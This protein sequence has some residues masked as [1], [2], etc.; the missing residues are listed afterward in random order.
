[1][2]AATQDEAWEQALHAAAIFAVDPAGTGVVLHGAPGPARDHFLTFVRDLL[3]GDTPMR[4]VPAGIGDERLLG[5]LDL[6]ATLKAGRPIV[7][8]GLLAESDGGVLVL[9]MA[10][11]LAAGTAARLAAAMDDG[12]VRLERDGVGQRLAARVGVVAL[13]E[14]RDE[15][16]TPPTALADRLAMRLDLDGLRGGSGGDLG[17][18]FAA[19]AI[20]AARADLPRVTLATDTIDIL[21][22]LSL[23]LGIASLR[24]S[25]HALQVA[26]IAAALRGADLVA[27]EDIEA[28]VRYVLLPRATVLPAP[29]PDQPTDHAQEPE[30]AESSPPDPSE[31]P[32]PESQDTDGE[33]AEGQT[34]EAAAEVILAAALATLPPGLLARLQGG[35]A[36]RQRVERSGRAGPAAAIGPRGRPIGTRHGDL[37]SGRLALVDTLRTAAPRQALRRRDDASDQARRVIVT[38]DDF[39]IRRHRPRR[40]TTAIFVVDASGSAAVHRLAEVKGAI[41]LLLADCYVRRDSVALAAFRGTGAEV[42]LPPTRSLARAKKLLAG[43][44]GGGGTPVSAGLDA[45]LELADRLRRKGRSPFIVLMTD[46]RANVAR[47]GRLGR[48]LALEDALDAGRQIRAARIPALAIDTAPLIQSGP[49]SPA[50]KI[51]EA[52][53]ARTIRLPQA[54]SA[55]VSQAVR[56]AIMAP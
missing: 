3:P 8:R 11:R 49:D 19:D 38:P 56:A 17:D 47:G 2:N 33:N 24:A 20:L 48:A 12:E 25:L 22:T 14:G 50:R 26:R 45:A 40:E 7:A 23:Q 46:G 10:E 27:D 51:G 43:L 13:D 30:E 9:A 5:G 4:R 18:P 31:T 44:P 28:A 16:E 35:G 29:E 36:S 37:R 34:P 1:M 53:A 6:A 21:V 15:D 42:V 39:R 55:H 52:M 54:D 41:E 32:P